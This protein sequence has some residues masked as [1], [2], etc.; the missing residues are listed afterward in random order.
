[1][2]SPG[3]CIDHLNQEDWFAWL[4]GDQI[5]T[6]RYVRTS[7]DT[8]GRSLPPVFWPDRT[9]DSITSLLY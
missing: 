4:R 1:M 9:S 5:E 7:Q 8:D 6:I 2:A 3:S